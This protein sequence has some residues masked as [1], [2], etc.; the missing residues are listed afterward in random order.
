V[1]RDQV[2]LHHILDAIS[3]IEQYIQ[4]GK[5]V[6]LL[7]PHWQDASIRQLEIIGE[8]S[9]RISTNLREIYP[10][11]PW[12]R[13]AGLRD[14]LIHEY[15]GVDINAVWEITQKNLPDLKIKIENILTDCSP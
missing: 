4:V 14:I 15:M 7:T 1:K 3:K 13:M 9:K 11:V 5:E 6:F 10:D 12:R 8:A 2:Y